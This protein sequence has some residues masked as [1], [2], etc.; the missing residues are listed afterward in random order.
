MISR[1]GKKI[2]LNIR[3]IS[4]FVSLWTVY[5]VSPVLW[6]ASEV[7]SPGCMTVHGSSFRRK[8]FTNK[9]TNGII[10]LYNRQRASK[11][12]EPLASPLIEGGPATGKSMAFQRRSFQLKKVSLCRE[13]NTRREL[14]SIHLTHSPPPA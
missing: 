2:G 4:I 6:A 13:V 1:S 10:V 12:E 5:A 8:N 9:T 3:L 7:S 14:M 11:K